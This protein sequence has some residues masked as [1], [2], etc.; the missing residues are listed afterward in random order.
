M[1][2]N[3]LMEDV[4]VDMDMNGNKDQRDFELEKVR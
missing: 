4:D 3:T 1:D 2:V